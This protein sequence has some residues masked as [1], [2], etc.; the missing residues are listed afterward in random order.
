MEEA[1]RKMCIKGHPSVTAGRK[2]RSINTF[3]DM[4]GI[5]DTLKTGKINHFAKKKSPIADQNL[6]K[7]NLLP[8]ERYREVLSYRK[9]GRKRLQ[10]ARIKVIRPSHDLFSINRDLINA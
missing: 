7:G 10:S 6:G 1:R 2:Q 9:N 4:Y 3:K 8:D 5:F